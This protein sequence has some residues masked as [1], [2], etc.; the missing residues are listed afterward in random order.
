M[1]RQSQL[2]NIETE[3]DGPPWIEPSGE[4]GKYWINWRSPS[5][6]VLVSEEDLRALV[7]AAIIAQAQPTPAGS[8]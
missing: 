2:I 5:L 4:A 1:P 7:A 8:L 6:G 3:P